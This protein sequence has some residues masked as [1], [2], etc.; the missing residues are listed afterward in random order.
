MPAG[1]ARQGVSRLGLTWKL[2]FVKCFTPF[3]IQSGCILDN[4]FVK[5]L[6]CIHSFVQVTKKCE[7]MTKL[8]R[9]RIFG[10]DYSYSPNRDGLANGTN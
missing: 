10:P 9:I 3:F 5:K 8:F 2:T 7:E 1:E 4:Y 6:L